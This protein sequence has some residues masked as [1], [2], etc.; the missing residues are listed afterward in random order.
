MDFFKKI[1]EV[2]ENLMWAFI[3]FKM[4]SCVGNVQTRIWKSK[5]L[6]FQIFGFF[7][8]EFVCFPRLINQK[9]KNSHERRI[10]LIAG[11][12]YTSLNLHSLQI[13]TR[14]TKFLIYMLDHTSGNLRRSKKNKKC[15][16]V[17]KVS[18]SHPRA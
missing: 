9:Q 1:S 13:P 4:F 8:F 10:Y 16:F 6:K 14:K 17:I 3:W 2:F 15:Y 7:R 11:L 5:N 12:I 18:L